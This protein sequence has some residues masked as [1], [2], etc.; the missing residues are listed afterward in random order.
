M[1]DTS[2]SFQ[3]IRESVVGLNQRVP[4][5]DGSFRTYINFDNAASTP[6]LGIVQEKVNAFLEWYSSVHRGTGFKSLISTSAFDE[7]RQII[8]DFVGARSEEH[9]VIFG[10]NS[11]E[12]IN[13]LAFRMALKPDDV[14]LVSLMEHHS[15][16]LPWRA[17]A[18]V[19]HIKVDPLG[20]LDEIDFE[21]KLTRLA[22]R[23]KL[24]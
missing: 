12:A 1:T 4:L 3:K 19:E 7:A 11:S 15:N 18:H 8:G 21:E 2:I 17:K 10:K 14:V 6:A 20:Q 13:K 16:D 9:V 23:V 5:L 24:V 22:G